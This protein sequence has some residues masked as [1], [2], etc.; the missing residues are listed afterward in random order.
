MKKELSSRQKN[1]LSFI[2]N[3]L[4]EHHYPPTIRDIQQGCKISST[5][6]VDYNLRILKEKGVLNRAA[7]VSRGIE[8][9]NNNTE[10][11]DPNLIEI[12]IMGNIAAGQP[13][14]IPESNDWTNSQVDSVSLPAFLTQ[15]K[16]NVFGVK[17][18]GESMIDALV[19]D[20]DLVLLE[21]ISRKP[22]N[23]EMVAALIKDQN[24][25]TLKHFFIKNGTVT[26]QPANSSMKPIEVD[27]ENVQ[28][29][30]KVVGVIRSI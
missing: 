3:F 11:A 22:N 28:V 29:Q 13:L 9:V 5:S 7:E 24:E 15:G 1:I 19:A 20:G 16:Q 14:H 12:P 27:A 18:K 30:G 2:E 4:E 8:L 10:K 23:G 6:V 25:I 26:L 17:V 21:P